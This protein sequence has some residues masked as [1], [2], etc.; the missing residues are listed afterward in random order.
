MVDNVTHEQR[1]RRAYYRASHRGTKEMDWLLGK[2]A[3]AALANMTD[4]DLALFEEMLA[5]PDSQVE[6]WIRHDAPPENYSGIVAEIR[7][8]HGLAS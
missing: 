3:D 1:L 7:R 8:F 4:G 6:H 5:M 2:Y